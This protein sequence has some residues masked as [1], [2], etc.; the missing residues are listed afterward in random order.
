[1]TV[2]MYSPVGNGPHRSAYKYFH[3]C[4]GTYIRLS[5]SNCDEGVTAWQN[6]HVFSKKN[7]LKNLREIFQI[8]FIIS[9]RM[10]SLRRLGSRITEGVRMQHRCWFNILMLDNSK[11]PFTNSIVLLMVNWSTICLLQFSFTCILQSI[12]H[13]VLRESNFMLIYEFRFGQILLHWLGS[14]VFI[15]NLKRISLVALVFPLLTLNK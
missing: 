2:N 11:T 6:G 9:C 1:M 15:I 3:G 14:D 12:I 5:S 8:R 10:S 13:F 7:L 4:D